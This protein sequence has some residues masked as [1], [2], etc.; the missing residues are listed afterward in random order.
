MAYDL[1]PHLD[2]D[3]CGL[4]VFECQEGVVG[5]GS[6]LPGLAAAFRDGQVLEHIA[7]LLDA[8]RGC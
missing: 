5:E 1:T 2:P 7:A 8:A 3:H 6:H 4:L